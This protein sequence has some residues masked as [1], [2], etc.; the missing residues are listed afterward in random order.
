M[1]RHL[2]LIPRRRVV[3]VAGMAVSLVVAGCVPPPPT[4]AAVYDAGC[5]G[6]LVAATPVAVASSAVTEL[7]GLSASR[8]NDGVLWVHNDSG[9][10]A[11][12]FAV[13]ASD[14]R[15][16]GEFD[17]AGANAVDW[18]DIAVAPSRTAGVSDLY[19][20]DIGDNT[21]SRGS[22]QVYRVPEPAVDTAV[23]D[24][25]PKTLSG[26]V[27]LTLRYPDGPHDAEALIVDPATRE[28]FILTK[29]LSSGTSQVFRAPADLPNGSTT[30]LTQ[31][32]TMSSGLTGLPGAVTAA[33]ISPAG[34]VIAVRTYAS[35]ALFPRPAGTVLS[36]A[37]E[38]RRC[39]GPFSLAEAQGE[40]L[41]FTHDGRGYVTASEG[42]RP[43]LHEF[44]AP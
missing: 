24:P 21:H 5:R 35:V 11:R 29:E 12:V 3:V 37:F 43:Q 25:P 34:D 36:A 1:R 31:V 28:V 7:S 15:N 4:G 9:D 32:A 40:A 42:A 33:D 41:G 2:H 14:G 10:V 19:V 17:L 39:N 38:R 23:V 8:K 20:G 16:L 18:E 26:V 27:A 13:R 30:V 22:V 44:R 6:A